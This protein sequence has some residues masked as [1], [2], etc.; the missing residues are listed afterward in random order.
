MTNKH[1][2][3]LEDRDYGSAE[4]AEMVGRDK[5]RINQLAREFPQWGR[6]VT[7]G[8]MV[9]WMFSKAGANKMLNWFAEN[10]HPLNKQSKRIQKKMFNGK[11]RY[12]KTV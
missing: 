10:G 4:L 11:G 1:A 2:F 8:K 12:G 3:H 6:R 5:S 9:F 7:H